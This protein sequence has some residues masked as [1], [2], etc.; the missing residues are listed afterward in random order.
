[1]KNTQSPLRCLV[2]KGKSDRSTKQHSKA[3]ELQ[4]KDNWQAASLSTLSLLVQPAAFPSSDLQQHT[5]TSLL[6]GSGNKTGHHCSSPCTQTPPDQKQFVTCTALV[7]FFL[8]P[9]WGRCVSELELNTPFSIRKQAAHLMQRVFWSTWLHCAMMI[10]S[11][12]VHR[13]RWIALTWLNAVRSLRCALGT[14]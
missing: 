7:I 14:L 6:Q 4:K 2:S 1:M 13:I 9:P 11:S 8:T 12:R 3:A 10:P 5:L